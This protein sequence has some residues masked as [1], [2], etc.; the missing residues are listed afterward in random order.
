ML[1]KQGANVNLVDKIGKTS[2]A[3]AALWGMFIGNVKNRKYSRITIR[4]R[5]IFLLIGHE[6]LAKLLIENGANLSL[7]DKLK[8]TPLHWAA[9]NG[10]L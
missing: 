10:I 8:R 2:I 1:I 4:N 6:M 5:H 3:W 7:S 9:Q